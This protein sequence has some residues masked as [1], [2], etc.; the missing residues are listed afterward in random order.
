MIATT[1]ERKEDEQSDEKNDASQ[2]VL[3]FNGALPMNVEAPAAHIQ[4]PP[5]QAPA[6][7]AYPSFPQF[8]IPAAMP[9]PPPLMNNN[10]NNNQQ[11]IAPGNNNI[12]G[13][14]LAANIN[15]DNVGNAV[16]V[17][18]YSAQSFNGPSFY[19]T[20]VGHYKQ[21]AIVSVAVFHRLGRR[22]GSSVLA[23]ELGM[24]SGTADKYLRFI[25][26]LINGQVRFSRVRDLN[27]DLQSFSRIVL[28]YSDYATV[29]ATSANNGYRLMTTAQV[30]Q[31]LS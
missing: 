18:P 15:V 24:K 14:P 27:Q 7:P 9:I 21:F 13:Q 28:G 8:D 4:A 6:L 31:L 26:A 20:K 30:E 23:T 19:P 1:S 3:R 12:V 10:N 22:C 11:V 16:G 29:T 17:D 5:I 2:D 25:M